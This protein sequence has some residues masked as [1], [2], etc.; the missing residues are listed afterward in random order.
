MIPTFGYIGDRVIT[1]LSVFHDGYAAMEGLGMSAETFEQN[2]AFCPIC[3]RGA[4][5]SGDGSFASA[6]NPA[7]TPEMVTG[8]LTCPH[9][10]SRFVVSMSGHCVRDP[11]LRRRAPSPSQLRRQSWPIARFLRDAQIPIA[12][13]V[14]ILLLGMTATPLRDRLPLARNP[15]SQLTIPGI[16]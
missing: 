5:Y 4:G 8:L 10:R 15:W 2:A 1:V 12:A 11:F 3:Y 6:L 13:S 9:C 16:R 7:L 14:A